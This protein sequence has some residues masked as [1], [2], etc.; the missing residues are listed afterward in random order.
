MI[1]APFYVFFDAKMAVFKWE[2]RFFMVVFGE[3][4]GHMADFDR[5]LTIHITLLDAMQRYRA[6]PDMASQTT[7]KKVD[8]IETLLKQSAKD[9]GLFQGEDGIRIGNA[10]SHF[11]RS[12]DPEAVV[13]LIEDKQ[14]NEIIAGLDRVKPTDK[15]LTLQ[16][17]KHFAYSSP[18]KM[19]RLK[20]RYDK[21]GEEY[22]II[23]H[24]QGE[25]LSDTIDELSK[26]ALAGRL[27]TG[28]ENLGSGLPP[29]P[30]SSAASGIG[31]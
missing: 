26:Q 27:A 12:K 25:S 22:G 3:F 30:A 9:N 18:F 16:E 2:P 21:A 31:R 6:T 20:S 7:A 11:L 28:S 14:I 4:R 24:S 15:P 5:K 17:A 10:W 8:T 29:K 1:F 19:A 23:R 13:K